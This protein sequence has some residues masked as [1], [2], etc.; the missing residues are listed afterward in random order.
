MATFR[1]N[2]NK[3]YTAISNYHLQD[4]NLSLKAK[5]LLS[6]M[7]SLPTNWNYSVRGLT[8]ICKETKD[9]INGVL[10]E[11]E[12]NNYLVRK[13]IYVN[14]KIS[15]WEYNIYETNNLYPK[16][17]DIENQDI[18]FYDNNKILNN[19]VLNNNINNNIYRHFENIFVRTLNG[20]EVQMIDNWLKDKTEEEIIN[21]IN[22]CAKSNID[23]FKYIE[24]VLYG[25]KKK[26]VEPSWFNKEIEESEITPDDDFKNFIEE[27]RK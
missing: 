3:N 9:T 23:N 27:F 11:L 20:I 7:L 6:L 24:K 1:I 5:G 26:K 2:K 8:E 13:R 25:K 17:Q 14:G 15:E 21:A 10:N 19:K 4:K 16:N 18:V 22:E 12:E